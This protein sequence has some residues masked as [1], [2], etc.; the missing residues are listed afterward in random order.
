MQIL[1]INT[2][3]ICQKEENWMKKKERERE[4]MESRILLTAAANL[5][6][7]E[8]AWNFHCPFPIFKGIAF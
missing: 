1:D 7:S 3:E 5:S 2:V 6:N 8:Y 4:R